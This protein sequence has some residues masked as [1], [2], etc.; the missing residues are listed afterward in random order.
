MKHIIRKGRPLAYDLKF[1]PAD[2]DEF[3]MTTLES[4]M[5]IAT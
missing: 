1:L 5:V 3:N 2:H 4:C